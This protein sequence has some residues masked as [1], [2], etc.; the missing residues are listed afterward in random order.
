[1]E[2]ILSQRQSSSRAINLSSIELSEC[3][4]SYNEDTGSNVSGAQTKIKLMARQA[5]IHKLDLRLL[6]I[7]SIIYLLSYLDRSNIANAK[8]GGL[9]HDIHLTSVQYQWSLSI[10]F[11]GYVLFEI[12]SNIIL[13]RW[14]PSRW[15]ALIMFSWGTIAVCMAAVSNFIGLLVC[16]FLLGAFEAGLFPGVIYFMS[17]WYPRK[18]QA[19]RLGFFWSFSALAGAFG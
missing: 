12:P 8:I 17:L 18:M 7:L 5:L 11:F 2:D 6:P 10:F 1:M 13:R 16:R 4:S 15:I 14:R 19:I 9:E 3:V